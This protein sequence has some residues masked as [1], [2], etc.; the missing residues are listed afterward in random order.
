MILPQYLSM[1]ANTFLP[2]NGAVIVTFQSQE[3]G[4]KGN[5]LSSKEN[6][7]QSAAIRLLSR[8]IKEPV[9]NELRTKQQLG[10]VSQLLL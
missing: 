7:Q 8:M 3:P 10:Y 6:L 4:F 2:E 5:S 1:H 9:F